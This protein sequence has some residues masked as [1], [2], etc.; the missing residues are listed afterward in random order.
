MQ[1]NENISRPMTTWLKLVDS[2]HKKSQLGELMFSLSYLPTAERLT[3]VVVKARNL[4]LKTRTNRTRGQQLVQ[5]SA[6]DE[7]EPTAEDQPIEVDSNE[8][9]FVKVRR[10]SSRGYGVITMTFRILGLLVE[11]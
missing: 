5:Q 3:V 1:I 4:N 7:G 11:E 9:I 6:I 8:S 2:S 10:I